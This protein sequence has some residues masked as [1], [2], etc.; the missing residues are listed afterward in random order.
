MQ[1][2]ITP[3]FS[4]LCPLETIGLVS[5]DVP[6]PWNLI[7]PF[8]R[9]PTGPLSKSR[10]KW[11]NY[12]S[13]N[14][15]KYDCKVTSNIEGFMPMVSE[16]TWNSFL[17]DCEHA[18]AT[19]TNFD[20]LISILSTNVRRVP[21]QDRH[22][23]SRFA[24]LQKYRHLPYV[25]DVCIDTDTCKLMLVL[26]QSETE[27]GLHNHPN[28]SGFIYCC[29]GEIQ[30]D[31]FDEHS[32]TARSAI[33]QQAYSTTLHAGDDAFLLPDNANIHR[34]KALTG[35]L[36]IDIFIPPP[37]EEDSH[38]CRRYELQEQIPNTRMYHAEIIPRARK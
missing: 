18:A 12:I 24:H 37:K 25:T 20:D 28:Q 8:L 27:I 10:C 7:K 32:A 15:A 35:S 21:P 30:V 23:A 33:L 16:Y 31:A 36:L 11:D 14:T 29:Q 19:F 2:I 9:K 22:L 13:Q 38:L 26:L 17:S 4:Y 1:N 6:F 5:L 34:L 3:H